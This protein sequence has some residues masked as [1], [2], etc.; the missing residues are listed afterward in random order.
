MASATGDHAG[1]MDAIYRSQRHFYD[2]TRKYYLLGR[3][4]LIAEL[5][6]PAGGAVIEIG[7]GTGRNLIAAAK[8]FPN[9]RYFG[10]D[11]SEAMLETARANVAKAGLSDRITLAQG[12]AT[13]FD[14]MAL[15]GVARFDRVFQSY[16]LSMIP[17][18]QGALR[19]GAG[20]LAQGGRLDVVDFGQQERLPG[21]FRALLFGWLAQFDVSPR[22]ELPATLDRIAAANGLT[23]RFMPLYR[24][25]A[26]SGRLS[27]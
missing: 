22:A 1:H 12:D 23:A 11:I 3:D 19:E 21:A 18:W 9:A 8:R 15:F 10:I 2:L 6:P 24:G 16:T 27:A 14:A 7:C 4:R 13:A 25:Y 20:K 26:W 5:A 17:D